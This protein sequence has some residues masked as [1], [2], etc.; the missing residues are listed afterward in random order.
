M[1]T[2]W[3]IIGASI[4]PS[5]DGEGPKWIPKNAD[6]SSDERERIDQTRKVRIIVIDDEAVIADTVVEI[7]KQEGFEAI[8]A[9][10]GPLAIE[11][12]KSW[13]PDI[14]LSDVIMPGLNGI[15]TGIKIREI[16]PSCK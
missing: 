1:A 9:S 4:F 15:E 12:A 8:G 14:L 7:L 16:V 5:F 10:T 6:L 3:Q 2:D 11:L 13:L